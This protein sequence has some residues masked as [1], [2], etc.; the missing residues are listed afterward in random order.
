MNSRM[1]AAC[2]LL[3]VAVAAG[4]TTTLDAP[5]VPTARAEHRSTKPP[6]VVYRELVTAV[7]RCHG[8]PALR[9]DADY[10]SDTRTGKIILFFSNSVAVFEFLRIE[11]ASDDG[12]GTRITTLHEARRDVFRRDIDAW[13][14]GNQ[15]ECG[16]SSFF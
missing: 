4:C 7:R 3:A 6:E 5:I 16:T 1:A 12:G 9:V 2:A 13:L 14:G 15:G 10:F 11:I 8:G